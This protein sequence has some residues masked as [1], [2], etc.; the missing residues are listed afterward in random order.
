MEMSVFTVVIEWREG[1]IGDLG[2][3]HLNIIWG[4]GSKVAYSF[5]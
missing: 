5:S 2:G 1:S 4:I 3:L